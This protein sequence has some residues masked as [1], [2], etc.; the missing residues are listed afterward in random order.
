MSTEQDGPPRPEEDGP[1]SA[2]VAAPP[3]A[4]DPA[5]PEAGGR[6]P[7]PQGEEAPPPSGKE[8]RTEQV[9][10]EEDPGG[11]PS[12]GEADSGGR[13]VSLS[14][15]SRPPSASD[16]LNLIPSHERIILPDDDEPEPHRIR[17]RPAPR[18]VQSM[19]SEALSQSS[20]RSS[21]YLRSMSGIPNL[22]ETL[23]ERQVLLIVIFFL[24]VTLISNDIL[25]FPL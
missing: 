20:R 7:P 25:C 2:P 6:A 19:V 16:I 8:G 9:L 17:P 1:P 13:S 21:R 5:P 12:A 14:E 18:M 11:A 15:R 22:Q 3:G 4:D 24:Y 23:K 10:P